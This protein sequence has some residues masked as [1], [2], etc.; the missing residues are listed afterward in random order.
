MPGT[1]GELKV[2]VHLEHSKLVVSCVE[3]GPSGQITE[4]K[5]RLVEPDLTDATGGAVIRQI[6]TEVR[7]ALDAVHAIT[8]TRPQGPRSLWSCLVR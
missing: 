3:C 5:R 6:D 7:A 2:V 1:A 4:L 8:Q